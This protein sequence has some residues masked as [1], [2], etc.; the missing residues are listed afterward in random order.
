MNNPKYRKLIAF[1]GLILSSALIYLCFRKVDLKSLMTGIQ[2]MD[3]IHLSTAII[4][5]PLI[6]LL[7]TL[8]WKTY[9][10]KMT[11][12]PF[13]RLGKIVS[14]WLGMSNLLPVYGGEAVAFY[15]LNREKNLKKT[16]ILSL[17]S[18]D[19]LVDGIALLR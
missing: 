17:F 7:K 16:A 14:V 4:I 19:Q 1:L 15:L 9:L 12:V 13:S 5:I 3:L 2:H 8:Q 10:P 6:I 11:N 18:I